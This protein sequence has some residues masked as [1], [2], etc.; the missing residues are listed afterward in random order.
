MLTLWLLPSKRKQPEYQSRMPVAVLPWIV[1]FVEL[2]NSSDLPLLVNELFVIRRFD[3]TLDADC[4]SN[5]TADSSVVV[6][7]LPRFPVKV[8]ESMMTLVRNPFVNPPSV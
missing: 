8:L 6:P 1:T 4:A 2:K 3:C 7:V 5:A